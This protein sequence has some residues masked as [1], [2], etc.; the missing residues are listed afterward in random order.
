MKKSFQVFGMWLTIFQTSGYFMLT[1]VRFKGCWAR[2]LNVIQTRFDCFMMAAETRFIFC[3]VVNKWDRIGIVKLQ[4]MS[5]GTGLCNNCWSKWINPMFS[6]RRRL[7]L[8]SSLTIKVSWIEQSILASIWDYDDWVITLELG[9]LVPVLSWETAQYAWI[10][11][12]KTTE[13]VCICSGII[14]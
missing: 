6:Q 13:L 5:Q 8:P 9:R 14:L 7:Q 10:C 11:T 2:H 12:W 3:G 4:T 1:P